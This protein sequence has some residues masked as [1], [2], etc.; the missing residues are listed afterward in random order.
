[1]YTVN[2]TQYV[3]RT[4]GH[5]PGNG[6]KEYKYAACQLQQSEARV[7]NFQDEFLK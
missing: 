7:K 6:R 2:H 3:Q 1:M 5:K 4:L